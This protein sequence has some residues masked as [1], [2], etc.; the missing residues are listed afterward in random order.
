MT[1]SR[2]STVFLFAVFL[3]SGPVVASEE[4][5]IARQN[6]TKRFPELLPADIRT[7]PVPGLYEINL[8]AQITYISANGNYL[9]Q[10]DLYDAE[11]QENLT[12]LRRT[13]VRVDAIAK[14]G[15]SS[16]I[17]FAPEEVKHT[18]YGFHGYRLWLLPE[19]A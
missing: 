19:V 7:T 9:L 10:G 15:E 3:M 18:D 17:V 1:F 11:S 12:E 2:F 14:I 6:I 8:G 4:D 5:E 13:T 16:M